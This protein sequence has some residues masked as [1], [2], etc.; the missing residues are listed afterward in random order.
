[1]GVNPIDY[2]NTWIFSYINHDF[3]RVALLR[4]SPIWTGQR[5]G[6]IILVRREPSREDPFLVQARL[7]L[8]RAELFPLN[9]GAMAPA[10]TPE[11]FSALFLRF[12]D[13]SR[14]RRDRMLKAGLSLAKDASSMSSIAE[15]N[16]FKPQK[17]WPPDFSQLNEKQQFRF[18]RKY[19]RRAKLKYTRPGWNKGVKLTSWVACSCMAV[20]PSYR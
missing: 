10:A 11:S 6:R 16:P 14:I 19:R 17:Q 8:L 4:M 12:P 3:E 20:F 9:P 13:S 18:E 2:T 5:T 1:M 7:H 15:P